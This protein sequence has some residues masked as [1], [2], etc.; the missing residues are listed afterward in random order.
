VGRIRREQPTTST[1]RRVG[2][3]V[4][5]FCTGAFLLVALPALSESNGSNSY[6]GGWIAMLAWMIA[7]PVWLIGLALNGLAES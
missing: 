5:L 7:C 3:A 6:A 1:L 4:L 2:Q